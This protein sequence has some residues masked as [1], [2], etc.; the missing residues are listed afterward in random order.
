MEGGSI[1]RAIRRIRLIVLV[2]AAAGI[3]A[4]LTALNVSGGRAASEIDS[5]SAHEAPSLPALA[6]EPSLPALAP[7]PSLP[8]LA[9][10]RPPT[11]GPSPAPVTA[12]AW[13]GENFETIRRLRIPYAVRGVYVT[14]WTAGG[15]KMADIL[16]LIDQGLVNAV[17]IDVKEDRGRITYRT[18]VPLARTVGADRERMI[19]DLDGLLDALHERNVYVI[20]RLVS[21]KDPLLATARPEWALRLKE[22]GLYR[23]AKGIAWIDAYQKPVWAYNADIAVELAEKGVQEIQLD[24]VRFPENGVVVDR[25]VRY[26]NPDGRSKAEVVADYIASVRERLR[27][28]PVFLSADVFG[29]VTTVADDMDIGQKWE[30]ISPRVDVISPMMYP[31]HY[32]PGSYGVPKPDLAPAAIIAAGLQ[33]AARKDAALRAA[34]Y[35]PAAVRPWYQAFS[36]PWLGKGNWMPY[37]PAEVKS[38]ITAGEAAGIRSY[39]LWDPANRYEAAYFR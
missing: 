39:L 9:P 21:F 7:E 18:D 10:D 31:S 37:G 32:A 25:L 16:A 11:A 17:V 2:F 3:P 8:A 12:S 14:G 22:G 36:A 38:Q 24:Y 6:P 35:R 13:N 5:K 20:A 1:G 30:L 28:Y 19:P 4:A 29:L 23:D 26:A 27:P 34:G 33:D 15:P